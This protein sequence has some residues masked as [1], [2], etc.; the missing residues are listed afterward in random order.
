MERELAKLDG[1]VTLLEQQRMMIETT[2]SDVSVFRVLGEGAVAVEHMTKQVSVEN[3]EDIRD[4]MEEQNAEV[5]ER[6]EFFIEAGKAGVVEEEDLLNELNE[7]EAEMAGKE[8]E[9]LELPS[10]RLEHAAGGP[11]PLPVK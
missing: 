2:V 5:E 1:Q 4:K 8:L 9:Q 3:L 7:L 11:L 10:V 6:R